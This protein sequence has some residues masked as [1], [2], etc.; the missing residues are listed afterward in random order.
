VIGLYSEEDTKITKK[1]KRTKEEKGRK[2]KKKEIFFILFM[3]SSFSLSVPSV[4]S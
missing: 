1:E 3:P 2:S 4:S